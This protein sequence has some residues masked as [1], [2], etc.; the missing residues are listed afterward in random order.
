MRL[1]ERTLFI[2]TAKAIKAGLPD[3]PRPPWWRFDERREWLKYHHARQ[4]MD[5]LLSSLA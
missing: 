4:V 5:E 2:D 1:T 3:Y